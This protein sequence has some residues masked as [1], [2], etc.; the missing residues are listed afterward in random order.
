MFV[1]AFQGSHNCTKCLNVKDGPFC[2]RECP[3]M[4][5][6]NSSSGECLTCYENCDGLKGCTGPGRYP[7]PGGCNACMN[8]GVVLES[9]SG[10]KECM[11]K[12]TCDEGYYSVT[13]YQKNISNTDEKEQVT[14]LTNFKNNYAWILLTH[15]TH[16]TT[17]KTNQLLQSLT[18]W[19]V[20]LQGFCIECQ[21]GCRICG[22]TSNRGELCTSC[23]NFLTDEDKCVDRCPDDN[24]EIRPNEEKVCKLR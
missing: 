14:F 18:K 3:M 11:N 20:L 15:M 5:Y 7:G 13:G 8:K 23:Y 21:A 1:Y 24:F 10:Q 17:A 9:L 22:F 6:A 2:R 19:M 16:V 12:T 4:K